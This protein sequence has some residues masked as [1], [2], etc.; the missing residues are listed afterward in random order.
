M[1]SLEACLSSIFF[2]TALRNLRYGKGPSHVQVL[3]NAL[4]LHY[5]NTYHFCFSR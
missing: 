1:R 4:V 2:F 3:S 5:S